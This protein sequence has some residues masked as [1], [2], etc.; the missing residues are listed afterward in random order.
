MEMHRSIDG[1]DA[2]RG[3]WTAALIGLLYLATAYANPVVGL[4]YSLVFLAAAWGIRKGQAWAAIAAALILVAPVV[5]AVF[6]GTFT[7]KI[8]ITETISTAV[9]VCLL[10]LAAILLVRAAWELWRGPQFSIW[11]AFLALAMAGSICYRPMMI[12]T[13]GMEDSLLIGDQMLVNTIQRHPQRGDMVLF[14]YPIDRKNI[15]VKRVA[16]V[17]G[18]RVHLENKKLFVNGAAVD[19]PYA[20]H[21]TTIIDYFR[22]NFPRA[23]NVRIFAPAQAMLNDNF[24]EGDIVVPEGKYFVLGD[25]R[26]YSLDSRYWGF[27]AESDIIGRPALIYASFDTSDGKP[28][29]VFTTRWSRLLHRL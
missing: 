13:G 2:R 5:G 21:K 18:D 20:L 24:R 7:N 10:L 15:F 17:A 12:P 22:D 27:I 26:D 14:E 28:A 29:S 23:P 11:I 16:A 8:G 25:N 9:G 3:F 1:V 4:A 19:E 6:R